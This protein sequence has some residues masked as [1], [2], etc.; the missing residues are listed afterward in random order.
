MDGEK[1]RAAALGEIEWERLV[2]LS[3]RAQP[4][5][6]KQQATARVGSQPQDGADHRL[7]E[8]RVQKLLA[9]EP[10]RSRLDHVDLVSGL[11]DLDVEGD[12]PCTEIQDGIEPGRLVAAQT[13]Q[14]GVG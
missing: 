4:A 7:L 10:A 11:L 9:R 5:G 14:A 1:I 12:P 3:A 2:A 6:P 8:G 13:H